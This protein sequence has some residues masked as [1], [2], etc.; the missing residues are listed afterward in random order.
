[1]LGRVGFVFAG[2][3]DF[4]AGRRGRY[5]RGSAMPDGQRLIFFK[6]SMTPRGLVKTRGDGRDQ[7]K[8]A[9]GGG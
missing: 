2:R 1:M 9:G 4:P 3:I 8:E 7:G 5:G 6:A